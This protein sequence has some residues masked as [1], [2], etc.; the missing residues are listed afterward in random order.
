MNCLNVTVLNAV[1][2]QAPLGIVYTTVPETFVPLKV[3]AET[4]PDRVVSFG[5]P[6]TVPKVTGMVDVPLDARTARDTNR[7]AVGELYAPPTRADVSIRR[8]LGAARRRRQST[9][10]RRVGFTRPVRFAGTQHPR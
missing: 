6:V 7:T 3:P 4:V 10:D 5:W 9:R 2:W 8:P 1:V